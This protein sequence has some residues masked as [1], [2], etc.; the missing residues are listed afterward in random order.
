MI[1]Y[2][3]DNWYNLENSDSMTMA[4]KNRVVNNPKY[5]PHIGERVY[6]GF[7]PSSIVKDVVYD[8]EHGIIVVTF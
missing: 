1:M 8:Y 6:L 4:Q 7:K 3:C 5:V 2:L